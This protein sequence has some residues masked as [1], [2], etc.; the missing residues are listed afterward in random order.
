VA[1]GG[2]LQERRR[3]LHAS[4]VAA[5]EA[6]YRDHLTDQ[7]ERL[8]YHAMR[9]AVWEKALLYSRQAGAALARMAC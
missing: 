5:S 4:I 3:T 1:Y 6:L 2:L 9:G 7:V 8:A